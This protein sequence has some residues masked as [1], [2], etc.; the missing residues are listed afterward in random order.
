MRTGAGIAATGSRTRA[1]FTL[2]RALFR[3]KCGALHL[4]RQS[5]FFLEKTWRPFFGHR[6]LCVSCQLPSNTGD[7]FLL[8]TVTFIHFTRSLGGRPLYLA[9]K[10]ICRSFCGGPFLWGPVRPN[11]LNIPKSAAVSVFAV[12]NYSLME[13]ACSVNTLGD[14]VL[15]LQ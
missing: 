13:L 3:R 2:S 10:K 8:I 6:R 9:R 5:L 4:R 12:F 14:G 7:L 1:G 11:M 15:Q